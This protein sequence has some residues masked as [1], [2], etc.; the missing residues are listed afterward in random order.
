MAKQDIAKAVKRVIINDKRYKK[1][2]K[3]F[4]ELP[5]YNLNVDEIEEELISLHE[6]RTVRRLRR[7]LEEP[8]FI[9]ETVKA[10]LKDQEVRSRITEIRISCV[11][12]SSKLED[13]LVAFKQYVFSEYYSEIN[14]ISTKGERDKVV[15]SCLRTFNK[16][17]GQI[18][19]VSEKC[20]LLIEDVDK[21]AYTL[22]NTIEAVKLI[23]HKSATV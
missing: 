16:Y 15:D 2:K 18:E 6:S 7:R 17:L 5:D 23:T 21:A 19:R 8:R 1:L 9:D 13:A 12:T 11:N 14:S 22:K 20:L 10:L 3:V 4:Q